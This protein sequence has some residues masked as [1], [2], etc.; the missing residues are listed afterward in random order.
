MADTKITEMVVGTP[1][2]DSLL[3]YV[4]DPSGSPAN[5]AVAYSTFESGLS[6]T[7][8]QISDLGTYL[9]STATDA[10]S[11]GFVVDEDNMAS[12]LATKLPTQQSVKAYV[13]SVI[14]GLTSL[15]S[16]DIDTLAEINAIIGD[17]TLVTV[18]ATDASGYGWVVDE[19]DMTSDSATKVPTQQ[20]VK[21]YVDAGGGGVTDHGALTGLSDDDHSQYLLT[22]GT[23]TGTGIQELLGLN[24]TDSTELT[25]SSGSV[26]ATQGYH[27][28]DTESDAATDDLD[29]VTVAGGEGDVL[30]L[31]AESSARTVV[32][33]HGTGNIQC[34][35]GYDLSLDSDYDYAILIRKDGSNWMAFS[36]A[37]RMPPYLG[38]GDTLGGALAGDIY[39][40]D[41]TTVT[42]LRKG[43]N[44]EILTLVSGL[45]GWATAS[46]SGSGFGFSPA[47]DTASEYSTPHLAG[48]LTTRS[49]TADNLYAFPV[50]IPFAEEIDFLAIE[51]TT[52]SSGNNLRVGLYEDDNGRPGD[53]VIDSGEISLTAASYKTTS[54]TAV[55]VSRGW[56]WLAVLSSA[57]VTVRAIDEERVTAFVGVGWSGGTTDATAIGLSISQTYGAM[58]DPFP[59]GN[60]S[61]VG[62]DVPYMQC[63]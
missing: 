27:T 22:A 24:L 34:A 11:W 28:V 56:Y 30:I 21:A 37:R 9:S 54:P 16:T 1:G 40:H 47:M 20:S 23:R 17:A 13:D 49:I 5:E 53:L 31:R 3:T 26:T 6:I 29:T 44:G 63:K 36:G 32:I 51:N 19:D 48:T 38:N 41:G 45:P 46:S 14:A 59:A 62:G 15:E 55:A 4:L 52:T 61:D 10:S 50:W 18:E 12:N 43:T 39:F 33:K 42:N 58:P 57:T 8:S 60:L 35:E 25:I 7:E 2:A